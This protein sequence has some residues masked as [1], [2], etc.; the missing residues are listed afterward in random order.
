MSDI[1]NFVIETY[2]IL[3]EVGLQKDKLHDTMFDILVS[4]ENNTILMGEH[5]IQDSFDHDDNL[6]VILYAYL[7]TLDNPDEYEDIEEDD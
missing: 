7:D 3:V 5:E 6:D 2:D 4:L 1:A